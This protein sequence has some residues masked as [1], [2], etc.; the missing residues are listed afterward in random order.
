VILA[1]VSIKKPVFATMMIVALLVLGWVSFTKLSVELFPNIDFPLVV[2]YTVYPG[3]GAESVEIEVT[4]EVEDAVN[5]ISGIERITS[6]SS[7][8]LST[9]IVEFELGVK[10]LDAA[11][12]VR[13]KVSSIRGEL[14]LDIEDPIVQRW[15][16]GTEP[17]LSI[18]I[19]GDR[20]PRDLTYI[21][22]EN[23]KKRLENISGIGSINLIGGYEREIQIELDLD[24]LESYDL[25]PFDVQY[26]I[27]AANFELPGGRL[28]KGSSELLVRTMGKVQSMDELKNL[29]MDTPKGHFVKLSDIAT[30]KDD[31][32]EIR[33]RTAQ[34][35]QHNNRPG[36][37]NLYPRRC[38]RCCDEPD[39]WRYSGN[40][41]CLPIPGQSAFDNHN[42]DCH[43]GFDYF[44]FHIHVGFGIYIEFYDSVGLVARCGSFNR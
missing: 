3:A 2:V 6:K 43:T 35:Y 26:E 15:D 16:P 40:S 36:Q 30:V 10:G 29:I 17:V 19:A 21:V 42:S 4:R 37:F 28:K 33:S 8:G 25:T 7:E 20:S 18:A 12:E 23:I 5:P 14:P 9:V 31:V 1:D 34:G 27:A 44:Y 24:L 41:G 39:L 13:D 11:Q 38:A 22:K 32:K